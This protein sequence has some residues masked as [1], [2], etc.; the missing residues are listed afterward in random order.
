[1]VAL[2][3]LSEIDTL[4]DVANVVPLTGLKVGVEAGDCRV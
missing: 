4:S 1:M 2:G 3:V